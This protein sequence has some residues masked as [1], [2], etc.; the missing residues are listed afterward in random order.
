[1]RLPLNA[2]PGFGLK[3]ANSI[4]EAREEKPFQSMADMRR[5]AKIGNV[6]IQ[7]L[8]EHGALGAMP[9]SDQQSLF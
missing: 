2:L 9:E 4:V 7:A 1:I 8:R 6:Q 5:R 3:V